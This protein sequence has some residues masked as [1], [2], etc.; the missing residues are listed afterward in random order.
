MEHG[1]ARSPRS[2]ACFS[3]RSHSSR[4]SFGGGHA[5]SPRFCASVRLVRA[6]TL[7]RNVP[8]A[9][10]RSR[11]CC[12]GWSSSFSKVHASQTQTLRYSVAT[13][14]GGLLL[15]VDISGSPCLPRICCLPL[16]W[17][18][19]LARTTA[20]LWLLLLRAGNEG[21]RGKRLSVMER[22]KWSCNSNTQARDAVKDLVSAFEC[23]SADHIFL[24]TCRAAALMIVDDCCIT[25]GSFAATDTSDTSK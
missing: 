10:H 5:T 7:V 21:F 22:A 1:C 6:S 25:V 23:Q 8:Q 17:N 24:C 19:G 14:G 18:C 12:C 15:V 4:E 3:Q 11:S 16:V 2:S 13:H 20:L 9:E